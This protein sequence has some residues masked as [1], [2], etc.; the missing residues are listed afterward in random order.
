MCGACAADQLAAHTFVCLF[1]CNLAASMI[2]AEGVAWLRSG[3]PRESP[4]RD[5]TVFLANSE[6]FE[7]SGWH[8]FSTDILEKICHSR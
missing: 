7:E 6:I 3:R 5:L 1:E 4:G 2:C 8:D